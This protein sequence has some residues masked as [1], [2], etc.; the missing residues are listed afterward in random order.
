M[1][2]NIFPVAED[3]ITDAVGP[4]LRCEG[5]LP[6]GT[7]KMALIPREAL[8]DTYAAYIHL[9]LYYCKWK[10][11]DIKAI[12]VAQIASTSIIRNEFHFCLGFNFIMSKVILSAISPQ[13]GHQKISHCSATMLP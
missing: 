10:D 6:L 13:L 3:F 12:P 7:T 9:G 8:C 1:Q 5:S 11:A 2:T 4:C